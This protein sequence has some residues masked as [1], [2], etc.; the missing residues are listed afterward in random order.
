MSH[1]DYLQFLRDQNK[2]LLQKLRVERLR[3]PWSVLLPPE[4]GSGLC[5]TDLSSAQ[6]RRAA[7]S[8][9]NGY[10]NRFEQEDANLLKNPNLKDQADSELPGQEMCDDGSQQPSEVVVTESQKKREASRAALYSPSVCRA[11]KQGW[12]LGAGDGAD[13]E[14]LNWL[15]GGEA[16]TIPKV[17]RNCFSSIRLLPKV[18]LTPVETLNK[19]KPERRLR[20]IPC[21]LL[22]DGHVTKTF[23]CS[24]PF[25]KPPLAPRLTRDPEP[26]IPRQSSTGGTSYKGNSPSHHSR[27]LQTLCE[28]AKPRSKLEPPLY[29]DRLLD[30]GNDR[31]REQFIRDT[32]KP[33]SILLGS[34][35]K[36]AKADD[37]GY[38]TFLSPKEESSLR[39]EVQ[40]MRPFL[41]YDWIAGLIDVDSPMSEKSEQYFMELQDFRRVNKEECVHQEYM[42]TE[43]LNVQAADQEKLDYNRHIHQCTHS[44]RVN[45]RLFAVPLEPAAVCPICKTPKSKRPHTMEEPAY[46]RVSIP[47]STLL[48]PHKYK[49]HRRKSFD[50]TD[51]LSLPSHCLLGWEST[52]PSNTPVA[53]TLDLRSTVEPK[54]PS[55]PFDLNLSNLSAA[56]SRVAGGTRS[57]ELLNLSRLTGYQFQRLRL[58]RPNSTSYPVY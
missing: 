46:V 26:P 43:E 55:S 37:V 24:T 2:H 29:V 6:N 4:S 1:S 58:D 56:A 49:P 47:R 8:R 57:D 38:V 33:K 23:N 40:A 52:M 50:P 5:P 45:S 44:Y 17:E 12:M 35:D 15:P 22:T 3:A 32:R 21:N 13:M 34:R 53:N 11:R 54:K 39:A 20:S 51:S 28:N 10:D 36:V 18:S 27:F 7:D 25:T 9:G 16:G 48:P 31:H 30:E 19:L 14:L 42:E 41:G